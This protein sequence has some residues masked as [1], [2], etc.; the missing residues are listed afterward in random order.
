MS[1]T[2]Y[3]GLLARAPTPG[4][5]KTRLNPRL[6]PDGACTFAKAALTDLLHLTGTLPSCR[7]ILFYTPATAR[8]ELQALLKSESLNDSWEL[9]C[10]SET[11]DLGGRLSGALDFIQNSHR[12]PTQSTAGVVSVSR[13]SVTFI[14]MDCFDLTPG[15]FS[16]AMHWPSTHHGNAFMIPAYD[17]GYV[18]LT[19]PLDCSG[20]A[21]FSQISW[22]SDQTGQM[23]VQRLM[24]AGL[25]CDVAQALPDVDEPADLDGLWKTREDKQTPFPRT[26]A[27]LSTVMSEQNA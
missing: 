16:T 10:Q 9:Q 1:C 8:P 24:D 3:L 7:R 5:S 21:I 18:L 17:G 6:G 11:P 25:T 4:R 19:V 20:E 23:Q 15:T 12:S 14:G 26:M 2:N 27:Y 13:P 22:S